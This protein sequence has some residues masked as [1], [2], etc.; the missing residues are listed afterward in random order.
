MEHSGK[1]GRIGSVPAIRQWS[2]EDGFSD[3]KVVHSGTAGGTSRSKGIFD[4]T[5]SCGGFG[6]T[7]PYFPGAIVPVELYKAPDAS[8][9]TANGDIANGN[10]H[11]NQVSIVLDFAT[12]QAIGW[13]MNFGGNGDL[14]WD[15]GA[16][17]VGVPQAEFPPCAG[18]VVLVADDGTTETIIPHVT[19]ATLT[20][21]NEAKTFVNSGTTTGTGKCTTG[22]A[23]GQG[24]DWTL[25]IASQDG[26][27]NAALASG[28]TVH[29]RVYVTATAFYSLKWGL[30]GKRS[31]LNVNVESGEIISQTYN[32]AQ[33]ILKAGVLGHVKKPD[34]GYL[35]GSA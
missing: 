16:M 24:L 2:L 7:P 11:I 22:R 3:N 29:V 12:N 1:F 28:T 4:W 17:P 15:T 14:V 34:L 5:G 6:H 21:T 27:E 8:G 10:I 9:D 19:Q 33:K 30:V 35:V 31:G 18:K 20:L 26:N 13:Q 32:I 25:A 23:A